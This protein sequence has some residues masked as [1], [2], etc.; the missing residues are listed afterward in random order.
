MPMTTK[1]V[2]GRVGSRQLL[3][4]ATVVVWSPRLKDTRLPDHI[5]MLLWAHAA[6]T[7]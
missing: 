5:R 4:G 2:I 1:Q 6:M 7:A 3:L